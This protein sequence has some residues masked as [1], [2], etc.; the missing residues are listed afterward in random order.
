MMRR[1]PRKQDA[2]SGPRG[3]AVLIASRNDTSYQDA[4]SH[5]NHCCGIHLDVL[6]HFCAPHSSKSDGRSRLRHNPP[7]SSTFSA[8]SVYQSGQYRPNARCLR[9]RLAIIHADLKPSRDS[10]GGSQ[11]IRP[12]RVIAKQPGNV[13]FRRIC[14]KEATSFNKF[15][16]TK[17]RAERPIISNHIRM[18]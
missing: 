10:N 6:P 7:R 5:K 3:S 1:R 17:P 18:E 16:A 8:P 11:L 13:S 15:D 14:N 4:C 12:P 9:K 2:N